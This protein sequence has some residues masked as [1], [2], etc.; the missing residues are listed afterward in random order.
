[1]MAAIVGKK[2]EPVTCGSCDFSSKRITAVEQHILEV[3]K[4]NAKQLYDELHDGPTLCKCGCGKETKWLNWKLGYSTMISGHNAS[5]YSVYN[6]EDAKKIAATRGSNWRDKESWS[7][8]LTKETDDRVASRGEA[9]SEGRKKAFKEGKIKTWSKGLTKE[10][11]ERVAIS[12]QAIKDNFKNGTVTP[13]AKGLTKKTD[14]RIRDM[15]FKVSLA[16]QQSSLR[17][18]LDEQ[19]RLKADEIRQRV[20]SS[21]KIQLV[22]NDSAYV[23]DNMPTI[24]VKCKKCGNEWVNTL[25]RLQY[26]RCFFCDPGGS[27]AQHEVKNWIESLGVKVESNRRDIIDGLELDIFVPA[28]KFAVEYNGLYWHSILH[29]STTYHDE[30]SQ[31][32]SNS[33]IVLFHLFEDEWRDKKSIVQ[34]M[35]KHR[36]GISPEKTS[37]RKCNLVDLTVQQRRTFFDE[38]HI[39]GDTNAKYAY[40]LIVNDEIVSAISL[41]TPFHKKHVKTLEVARFCNKINYSVAGGLSRLTN[42]SKMVAQQD[43]LE[44]LLSYVDTRI[45]TRGGWEQA[46]WK[47]VQSTPPRFWWTNFDDRFNRF[48]YKADKVRNMSEA[49][50]ADEANV[51][52]I[53]GCKNLTYELKCID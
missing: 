24:R 46:G 43:G 29:K 23:N 12:S 11:D 16:H 33:G 34:S 4:K 51:V 45:G 3:H 44:S 28:H 22:E 48:K 38:N 36:L 32:C 53:Y 35:I 17:N 10:T 31:R 42:H 15:A 41:R 8:G 13:W 52:K 5:I 26:G 7:K 6:E 18:K 49:Q 9:T 40:G 1:M 2:L 21:G 37:A 50:V 19:K 25:R 30:K 39:D 47:F 20:E 14:K 27:I